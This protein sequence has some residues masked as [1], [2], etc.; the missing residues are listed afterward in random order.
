[1]VLLDEGFTNWLDVLVHSVRCGVICGHFTIFI[2]KKILT[3]LCKYMTIEY[4]TFF[5]RI[6]LMLDSTSKVVN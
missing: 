3:N 4:Y 6:N 1:M 2:C 5:S